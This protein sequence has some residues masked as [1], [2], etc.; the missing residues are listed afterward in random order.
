MTQEELEQEWRDR[1]N[2]GAKT[3]EDLNN[4]SV[5]DWA[6]L[7]DDE[8]APGDLGMVDLGIRDTAH[9]PQI[10]PEKPLGDYT[11]E[12]WAAFMDEDGGNSHAVNLFE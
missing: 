4:M 3:E 9:R 8:C 7:M 6:K 11:V 12:E 5:A 2:A 1:N 10:M